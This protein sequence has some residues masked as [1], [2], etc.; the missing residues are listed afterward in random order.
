V[1]LEDKRATLRSGS[2]G[3]NFFCR[4]AEN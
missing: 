3:G 4:T 1:R 2:A